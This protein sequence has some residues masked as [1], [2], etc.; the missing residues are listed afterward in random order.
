MG[1]A[2]G[3][4]ARAGGKVVDETLPG[5][6][7]SEA[8]GPLKQHLCPDPLSSAVLK[9]DTPGD[10]AED[11]G[12]VFTSKSWKTEASREPQAGPN[13]VRFAGSDAENDAEGDA[14]DKGPER[15]ANWATRPTR[16]QQAPGAAPLPSSVAPQQRPPA[17]AAGKPPLA[18]NRHDAAAQKK[19]PRSNKAS[20][21]TDAASPVVSLGGRTAARD[22]SDSSRAPMPVLKTQ[23]ERTDS[24]HD[25]GILHDACAPD[26]P[27]GRAKSVRFAVPN[28]QTRHSM[29]E[30]AYGP[31]PA[32]ME[33][34]TKLKSSKSRP[35][36]ALESRSSRAEA[37][38][39]LAD[40]ANDF[41]DDDGDER[42]RT[43]GTLTG[44]QL[45]A[46][47]VMNEM[48]EVAD[49]GDEPPERPDPL[50]GGLGR[51]PSGRDQFRPEP[52][53]AR[54]A[55]ANRDLFKSLRVIQRGSFSDMY[56]LGEC[57]GSGAYGKAHRAVRK[58][59]GTVLVVKVIE[60]Q[61]MN[62][63]MKR[64]VRNEVKVLGSLD[65][66]NVVH[67][68]EC[69][70]EEP[71][72]FIVMEFCEDGDLTNKVKQRNPGA[73]GAF[74]G[75]KGPPPRYMD[76]DSVMLIFVQ[77]CLALH[78]THSRGV[79]HRDLKPSNVLVA[80]GGIVKLGDFGIARVTDS[81][82][83][84]AKTVVGT[85]YYLSPEICEDRPYGT[86]S[87]MWSLGCVL[88][89]LCALHRPFDGKSLPS[90]VVKI[91]EASYPPL[92][93]QY[94]QDLVD[95]V[96]AL[97]RRKPEDRATLDEILN[98]EYVRE[99]LVRY[100]EAI[101]KL[102][103][104]RMSSFKRALG[105][106]N[107]ETPFESR[108]ASRAPSMGQRSGGLSGYNSQALTVE[109]ETEADP[110]SGELESP[111]AAARPPAQRRSRGPSM[112]QVPD[113]EPREIPDAARP[114]VRRK[115][116][117]VR[118]LLPALEDLKVAKLKRRNSNDEM[119]EV[120]KV[121]AKHIHR[122]HTRR[123]SLVAPGAPPPHLANLRPQI[124]SDHAA[125]R[126]GLVGHSAVSAGEPGAAPAG[127]KSEPGPPARGMQQARSEGR[128]QLKRCQTVNS[129]AANNVLKQVS[130]LM[131]QPS[132]RYLRPSGHADAYVPQPVTPG[133]ASM[134]TSG[135]AGGSDR[136]DLQSL[137]KSKSSGR[138]LGAKSGMTGI[139]DRSGR[140]LLPA[141][142]DEDD[143]GEEGGGSPDQ[144]SGLDR[145][146]S[147]YTVGGEE[148]GGESEDGAGRRPR[149]VRMKSMEGARKSMNADVEEGHQSTPFRALRVKLHSLGVTGANLK[150]TMGG[151]SEVDSEDLPPLP[152][153]VVERTSS[154][155]APEDP[156][157]PRRRSPAEL[158]A[159]IEEVREQAEEMLNPLILEAAVA[160][161]K[162]SKVSSDSGRAFDA[163]TF[164]RI[165]GL[166]E[167]KVHACG[168]L[169]YKI[170]VYEEELA[171]ME[172][173]YPDE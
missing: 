29:D 98:L 84:M 3:V 131:A 82:A 128:G 86:A 32:R 111:L 95:L 132:R 141:I 103:P 57:I 71:N 169:V 31:A 96:G 47:E 130:A 61:G 113:A 30:E 78:H 51:G 146:H 90:L 21:R 120:R 11:G 101:R 170:C 74:N 137:A 152:R 156:T 167:E 110:D 68:F 163:D 26:S 157:T 133:A 118:E 17:G 85:P 55:F 19:A 139:S 158:R 149:F 161:L 168:K 129:K 72:L 49:D 22:S 58:V 147:R 80:A 171:F 27:I 125:P 121:V 105:E 4:P 7:L 89:E 13:G 59:D 159:R 38:A 65:H 140:G 16:K 43:M 154:A 2:C 34:I 40:I 126:D 88:Y 99:H 155:G 97:L 1:S 153:G 18:G 123:A 116:E 160:Y 108:A 54:D 119:Y 64:E 66:P 46:A 83:Q 77:I 145:A 44:W 36:S 60:F 14:A 134:A 100:A 92:P 23:K 15:L 104:E 151:E 165:V 102:S 33:E 20:I 62:E 114:Q 136:S 6:L 39:R 73:V 122:K 172:A 143:E 164:R 67:Y 35:H 75:A 45:I 37:D 124:A 12:G 144:R 91:L 115:L 56:E 24:D 106:W 162:N 28:E 166:D 117:Q 81:D 173:Q 150:H 8:K 48:A 70:V 148:T 50:R 9:L 76:E 10:S 42:D 142:V 63:R 25:G 53:K 112:F 69:F 107:V 93:P 109:T 127:E 94:S 41:D 52:L 138:S 5:D 135:G 87:D 79:L